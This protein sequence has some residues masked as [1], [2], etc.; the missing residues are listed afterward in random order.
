MLSGFRLTSCTSVVY[1]G[2]KLGL[3]VSNSVIKICSVLEFNLQSVVERYKYG[4]SLLTMC[5]Y[6]Q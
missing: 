6:D 5:D 3:V 4:S 1:H 2:R